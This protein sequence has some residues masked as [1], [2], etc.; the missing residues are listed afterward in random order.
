MSKVVPNYAQPTVEKLQAEIALHHKTNIMSHANNM[1]IIAELEAQNADLA[2]WKEQWN[3]SLE[4]SHS[5]V[6]AFA[7]ETMV[8]EL[9]PKFAGVQSKLAVKDIYKYAENLRK[10][11]E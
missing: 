5:R 6:A 10:P 4:T 7:I 11:Y 2:A 1:R 8:G 3:D 9:L